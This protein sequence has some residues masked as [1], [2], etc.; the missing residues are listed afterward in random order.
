MLSP[1]RIGEKLFEWALVLIIAASWAAPQWK[2]GS[3][4][5]AGPA[6]LARAEQ[7]KRIRIQAAM[8][9]KEAARYEADAEIERA[10]GIAEANKIIAKALG[11]PEGYLRWRY[12]EML[13]E[14]GGRGRETIY[15]PT[16]A[17]LPIL[18]AGKRKLR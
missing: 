1:C 10:R 17:G 4:G 9:L 13:Q 12:I 16:E 2:V 8:S 15:V 7:N 6:E 14:T 5:L 3:Q 11:G 18:E